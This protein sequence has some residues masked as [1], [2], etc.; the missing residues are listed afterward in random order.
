MDIKSKKISIDKKSEI[1]IFQDE[2]VI[3]DEMNNIIKSDYVLYDNKLKKLD[4]K[5]NVLV[6]TAEGYSIESKNIILDKEKNILF[7]KSYST[8]QDIEKNEIFLENFEYHIKEKKIK[9]IGNIKVID[10]QGNTYKFSQM[11][12]DEKIK[13]F[14]GLMLKPF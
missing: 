14:L 8:I 2:V 4:I 1:T 5:G 13:N 10:R 3:K 12:I 9:S 11:Y 6:F 7:S